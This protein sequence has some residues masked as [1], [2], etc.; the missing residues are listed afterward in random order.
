MTITAFDIWL[1][2]VVGPLNIVLFYSALILFGLATA[3]TYNFGREE[4]FSLKQAVI[5]IAV[6]MTVALAWVATPNTKT[7]SA[8]LVLPAIVNNSQVAQELP[9]DMVSAAKVWMKDYI[10]EK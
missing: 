4:G 6:A 2:G 3:I 10:G 1:I 8:M 5:S 7:A 9:E